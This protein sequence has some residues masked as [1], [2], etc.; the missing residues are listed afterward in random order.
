MRPENLS[1]DLSAPG[2]KKALIS[3]FIKLSLLLTTWFIV[4]HHVVKPSGILDVPL[5]N[6][7]SAGVVKIVNLVSPNTAPIS[8]V[9]HS[10][11][12][13]NYLVQNNRIV[14]GID[15][16]CNG[17]DLMFTYI[18]LIILL[19]YPIKRKLVFSILGIIIISFANIIRVTALYFIYVYH[20]SAFDFSHHYL[21]TISMDVLIFYGWLLFIKKKKLS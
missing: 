20:K 1:Y 7:I 21:F 15:Y 13:S 11:N 6:F 16:V 4:Y 3:F 10:N 14:L 5:T 2:A 17:I 18:S 12:H 9:K 8:W 19:P